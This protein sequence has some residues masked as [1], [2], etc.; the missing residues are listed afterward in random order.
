MGEPASQSYVSRGGEK[1]AAALDQF[2]I[3]V[4]G[5]V[6]ADLGSHVGGFVDCLLQRG[7]AKVYSVDTSYGTLAWTLR[8]DSRVVV[9]ERTNAMHV[10]LP[11][12]VDLVTIDVGWTRQAKVL[13]NV[14]K[15][16]KPDGQVVTLLKP[17][18][19]GP[20]APPLTTKGEKRGRAERRVRRADQGS[21]TD[22]V[23]SDEA[24]REVVDRVLREIEGM[25]WSIHGS[26]TSPIRGQGG[27]MEVLARLAQVRTAD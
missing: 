7:A 17:Q 23:L 4:A 9:L 21:K 11:E 15:L 16:L 8:K 1:L 20:I 6:C 14:A 26:C 27:N 2:G 22:T 24:A 19:E 25:G 5:S 18:Y 3:D 13:P 10:A 12:P